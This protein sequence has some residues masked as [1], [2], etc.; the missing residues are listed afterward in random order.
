M[1]WQQSFAVN[2]C[3]MSKACGHQQIESLKNWNKVFPSLQPPPVIAALRI[4]LQFSLQYLKSCSVGL[5]P[6]PIWQVKDFPFL[7]LQKVLSCFHSMTKFI[8]HVHREPTSCQFCSI[9]AEITAL[10]PSEFIL[11]LL[12]AVSPFHWVHTCPG[13]NAASCVWRVIQF[14]SDPDLLPFL[15]HTFLFTSCHYD[16]DVPAPEYYRVTQIYIR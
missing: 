1:L 14:A 11:L 4:C 7:Y 2:E 10:Y 15:L 5:S 12:S 8:I 9:G 16:S 13:L 6:G 3:L